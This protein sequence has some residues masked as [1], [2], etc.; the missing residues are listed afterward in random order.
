MRSRR[1]RT[2]MSNAMNTVPAS[3]SHNIGEPNPEIRNLGGGKAR[4]YSSDP[5]AWNPDTAK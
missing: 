5:I 2:P 3:N 1:S 4:G